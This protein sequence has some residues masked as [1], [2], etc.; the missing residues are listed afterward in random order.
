MKKAECCQALT[1]QMTLCALALQEQ[2]QRV[3]E[4]IQQLDEMHVPEHALKGH[5][6]HTYHL[7]SPDGTVDFEFQHNVCGRQIYA[8]GTV[9]AAIFLGTKVAERT[10]K[11]I[12]NMVDVLR[13]GAMR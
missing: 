12:F 6:F 11:R 10:S 1:V 8:E 9:D 5:A 2:I 7:K 3:R 13:A 4:P